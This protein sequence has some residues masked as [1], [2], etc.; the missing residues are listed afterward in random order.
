MHPQDDVAAAERRKYERM[1]ALPDYREYEG[2][3][4]LAERC[5][6]LLRIA[7]GATILDVGCGSGHAARLFHERG[8]TVFAA[9]VASNALIAENAPCVARFVLGPAWDLPP[10]LRA[11][12][13][14]CADVMEHLPPD[15]VDATLSSIR[16]CVAG[17]CFFDVSL[18]EDRLGHL[19]GETLHLTVQP[20]AWWV[21]TLRRHW[22]GVTVAR[23]NERRRSATL[24]AGPGADPAA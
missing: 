23:T 20:L 1:W 5:L 9:D 10:D 19:I 6:D 18:R 13:A 4:T 2:S 17:T 22:P 24:L 12:H 11:D 3:R 14:F 21:D 15:R 7:P 8:L 16:R